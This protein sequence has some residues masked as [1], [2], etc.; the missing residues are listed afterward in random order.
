MVLALVVALA[1]AAWAEPGVELRLALSEVLK[2]GDGLPSVRFV[3]VTEDSR[4]PA[5]AVCVWQGRADVVID[6][7]GAGRVELSTE[8]R[9]RWWDAGRW[10]VQ[11]E[12][13]RPL[14]DPSGPPPD[15][16]LTIRIATR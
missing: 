7:E 5:H 15:Y 8:E 10:M 3:G 11:L 16:V 1:P 4:C 13:L 6:V 14:P 2:P 12:S 9:G